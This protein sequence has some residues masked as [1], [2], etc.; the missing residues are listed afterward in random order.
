MPD[1]GHSEPGC[2]IPATQ[3]P[4]CLIPAPQ[5][6]PPAREPA[7]LTALHRGI[8]RP[9]GPRASG[10]SGAAGRTRAVKGRAACRASTVGGQKAP[11][12][13]LWPDFGTTRSP[14]PPEAPGGGMSPPPV[15][16]A[17][18]SDAPRATVTPPAR[19]RLRGPKGRCSRRRPGA[20][21][22]VTRRAGEPPL[23]PIA[24]TT[25][26]CLDEDGRCGDEDAGRLDGWGRKGRAEFFSGA[27][28]AQGIRGLGRTSQ[29][30]EAGV[31]PRCG[32]GRGTS[33]PLPPRALAR[34]GGG[35]GWGGP[36]RSRW[37]SSGRPL[38]STGH[39]PA[40]TAPPP[41][42]SLPSASGGRGN[43][44]PLRH[45]RPAASGASSPSPAGGGS[46][47]A[48]RRGGV[49]VFRLRAP[50]RSRHG[51]L[52]PPRCRSAQAT[53]PLQGRVKAAPGPPDRVFDEEVGRS[54]T[55][56][57]ARGAAEA[58]RV[59]VGAGQGLSRSGPVR[60]M[61]QAAAAAPLG[62]RCPGRTFI[63]TA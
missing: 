14:A 4:G 61:E 15:P 50:P 56:A 9:P 35:S 12:R 45:C 29:G 58:A 53:L 10:A 21:G 8:C 51:R 37:R 54:R 6:P 40:W 43:G 59:D 25:G 22:L 18:P 55:P 52:T 13:R 5:E 49:L 11:P 60:R 39:R 24:R 62:K 19:Q 36:G 2:L 7:R 28:K 30:D 17:P 20:R 38:P 16:R 3:K 44:A 46:A 42:T 47:T 32:A 57:S 63:G 1:P 26:R 33:Y 31:V 34:G 41:L 23:R 27:G 48:G